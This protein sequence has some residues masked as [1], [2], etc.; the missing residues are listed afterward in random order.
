MTGK[1]KNNPA[2]YTC[3]VYALVSGVTL[4]ILTTII[5]AWITAR[6]FHDLGLDWGFIVLVVFVPIL[7]LVIG[8]VT[9]LSI[10][11]HAWLLKRIKGMP[12]SRAF[13]WTWI[14]TWAIA[15]LILAILFLVS[16]SGIHFVDTM[17][18]GILIIVAM[19]IVIGSRLAI[20]STQ[21]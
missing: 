20:R 12:P 3:V 5:L 18:N 9:M 11:I 16:V 4:A 10:G 15:V 8:A 21:R 7:G 6:S 2:K 19:A 13:Y 1:S 14:V 17:V